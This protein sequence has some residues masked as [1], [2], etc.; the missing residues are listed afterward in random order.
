MNAHKD[1]TVYYTAVINYFLVIINLRT[2]AVIGGISFVSSLKFL[3]LYNHTLY[4]C[5]FQKYYKKKLFAII[6]RGLCN[7]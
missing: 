1:G 7:I 6:V 4:F 5:K 3:L 2:N